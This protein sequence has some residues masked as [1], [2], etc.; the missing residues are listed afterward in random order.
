MLVTAETDKE[1]LVKQL[2]N[3]A[4]WFNGGVLGGIGGITTGAV[5]DYLTKD[6]PGV[7]GK[8]RLAKAIGA[9]IPTAG[10][11]AL[12]YNKYKKLKKGIA[13]Y[14][15]KYGRNQS[16]KKK[17]SLRKFSGEFDINWLQD[18]P[19]L[20]S[21]MYN[22]LGPDNDKRVDLPLSPNEDIQRY[23]T[24]E[25]PTTVNERS[26]ANALS[27]SRYYSQVDKEKVNDF[28]K[29]MHGLTD[30]EFRTGHVPTQRMPLDNTKQR[31]SRSKNTKASEST[32]V[33]KA[34]GNTKSKSKISGKKLA[35]GGLGTL[36]LIGVGMLAK[37]IYDKYK[38]K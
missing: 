8:L 6:N 20:R 2:N 19:K 24:K 13:E 21:V 11:L 30:N 38:D 34:P 31:A 32:K 4:L 27:A 17:A 1:R 9:G 16:L 33:N 5:M 28:T 29:W 23:G 37:H 3:D 22:M 10:A 18:D 15:E 14:N 35:I 7:T 12:A 36:G 25:K 26:S